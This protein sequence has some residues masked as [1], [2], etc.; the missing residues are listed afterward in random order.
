MIFADMKTMDAGNLEAGIAFKAGADLI[1]VLGSADGSTVVG[2]AKTAKAHNKGI[3]VDLI[4]VANK[5]IRAK[6]ARDLGA[7]FVEF[8]AGLDEQAQPGYNLSGL[9]RAGEEA[10]VPLFVVGGLNAATIERSR[11]ACGCRRAR[12]RKFYLRSRR[13]GIRCQATSRRH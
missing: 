9:L 6:E 12:G 11:P 10:L 2:A 3:V 4:G 5:A 7:T 13:P 8:H 1:S